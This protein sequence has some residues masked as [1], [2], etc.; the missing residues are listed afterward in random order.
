MAKMILGNKLVIDTTYYADLAEKSKIETKKRVAKVVSDKLETFID[1]INWHSTMRASA[2][3]S[4]GMEVNRGSVDTPLENAKVVTKVSGHKYTVYVKHKNEDGKNIFD[5]IDA[6]T[7]DKIATKHG[8]FPCY[9]GNITRE[10]SFRTYD[11]KLKRLLDGKI[12]VYRFKPGYVIQ[13][14]K[15]KYFYEAA[16]DYVYDNWGRIY[17]KARDVKGRFTFTVK[18]TDIIMRITEKKRR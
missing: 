17:F 8:F 3:E 2:L 4:A 13:G 14:N 12:K 6:G 5:M 16:I 7:N 10:R 1:D 11:V 18:K 9:Q 15:P